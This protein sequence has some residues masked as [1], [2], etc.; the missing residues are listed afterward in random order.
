MTGEYAEDYFVRYGDRS[1]VIDRTFYD[2]LANISKAYDKIKLGLLVTWKELIFE[3]L[4][5]PEHQEVI[6]DDEVTLIPFI[7]NTIMI[8]DTKSNIF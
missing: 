8:V 2:T 4:D 1:G 6:K 7:G 5:I 3:P